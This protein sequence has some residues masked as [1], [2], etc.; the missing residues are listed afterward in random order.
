MLNSDPIFLKQLAAVDAS[1]DLKMEAVADYLRTAADKTRWAADG[2]VL[3]ESFDDLDATLKRHHTLQRDEVED[4]EK[5]LAPEERGRSLYRRCTYLQLP[6]DG[7]PLPTHFIPGAFNDLA[8]KL[9]VGWHPSYEV[10]FGEAA[11]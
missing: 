5:A 9:V 4:T 10:L 6:L 7:Q 11:E 3:E 2:L 1:A 8:D